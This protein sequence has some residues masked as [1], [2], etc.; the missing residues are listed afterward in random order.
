[1]LFAKIHIKFYDKA[2]GKILVLFLLFVICFA[3]L[4]IK[5]KG[6]LKYLALGD[7]YTIGESVNQLLTFPFL[8]ENRLR[9]DAKIELAQTKVIAKTGWTTAELLK[10]IQSVKP[11]P[12]YDL[13][14]LL[15]GVN[16]QYRGQDIE[17]YKVELQT[18]I[19]QSVGF[20]KGKSGHVIM[21]SIPDY[22]CTPFGMEMA[23]KI[24]LE[25]RQYNSINKE[26]AKKNG[27]QWVDVF[28]TSKKAGSNPELIASDNLHPSAA[29]YA[30]W[31]Q[32]IFPVAK[33]I[34]EN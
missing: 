31:V 11:K 20:A 13:V 2:P 4:A 24:D 3:T 9:N 15:I 33:S 14:T 30:L 23:N 28:E 10:G 18:L 26:L 25:L 6:K 1:L 29:M 17:I 22:G 5:P 32:D 21:I 8:L 7:S 12:E 19:N 27:L 16:N 34:L